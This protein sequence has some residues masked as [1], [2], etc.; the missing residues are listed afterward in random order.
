M[1]ATYKSLTYRVATLNIMFERPMD[2]FVEGSNKQ[3]TGHLRL[4][5]DMTGYRLEEIGVDGGSYDISPRMNAGDMQMFLEGLVR[6]AGLQSN[7]F[8]AMVIQAKLAEHTEEK[9]PMYGAEVVKE[10]AKYKRLK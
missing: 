6:G 2:Q 10:L 9:F 1:R 4:D 8:G 5:K 3:N 7:Y